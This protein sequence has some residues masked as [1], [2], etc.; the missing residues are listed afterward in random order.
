MTYSRKNLYALGEPLGQCVTRRK[1]GGGL[2]CGGGGGGGGESTSN[3]PTTT[4]TDRRAALDKSLAIGDGSR[5]GN[6]SMTSYSADAQVLQTLA[7]TMPDAV[8]AMTSA[9]ADVISRAGGSIVDLNRDSMAANTRSFDSVVNFGASAIDKIIDASVQTTQVGNALA[10]QAV[11]SYQP[12]E[13]N[14]A[15]IMKYGMYAAAAV[16]AVVLLKGRN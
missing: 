2:L 14:N 11:A 12:A 4:N 7:E 3:S 9:G 6:I 8:K 10:A 1:V 13:K 15:D 16:V 5:T